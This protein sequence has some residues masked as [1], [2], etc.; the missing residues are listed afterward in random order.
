M[1]PPV[2]GGDLTILV[3]AIASPAAFSP[4]GDMN[5]YRR[6]STRGET[7]HSVFG[8][9]LQYIVPGKRD[10]TMEIGGFLTL[11]DAGQV[12]L[13]AAEAAKTDVIV[14][15]LFDGTNGFTQQCSVSSFSHDA[16]P[17]D[18]ENHGFTLVPNADAVVVGT[19]PIL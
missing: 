5:S 17:D 15:I 16:N 19:G 14:K 18:L 2:S 4:V 6:G 3:A 12:I 10:Q 9:T 11:A 13:R 1:P 8:R 7:R